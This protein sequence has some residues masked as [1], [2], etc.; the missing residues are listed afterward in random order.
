M[1]YRVLSAYFAR[2]G[3]AE[4]ALRQ[5]ASLG[6]S[7]ACISL[8]PKHAGHRDDLVVLARTKATEGAALG[9]MGGGVAGAALGALG[10][11]GSVIAP[12]LGVVLAGPLVGALMVAAVGGLIGMAIGAFIGVLT[13]DYQVR[14]VSD[15]VRRGGA[16]IAVRCFGPHGRAIV[17][18]LEHSGACRVHWEKAWLS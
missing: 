7:A 17:R 3:D 4:E 2:R 9:A 15:A 13:P 5:L 6:V 14:Y 11:G 12:V 16:L 10:A 18:T 8:L 1:E